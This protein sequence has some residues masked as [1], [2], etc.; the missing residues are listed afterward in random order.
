MTVQQQKLLKIAGTAL[1]IVIVAWGMGKLARIQIRLSDEAVTA[2]SDLRDPSPFRA[3][4][5]GHLDKAHLNALGYL[6]TRD[7]A[8]PDQVR[9]SEAEFERSVPEFERQ[10]PKLLPRSAGREIL[11]DYALFK[12]SVGR[13]LEVTRERTEHLNSWQLNADRIHKLIDLRLRP[14]VRPGQ[15]Q[16]EERSEA[17]LKVENQ[18]RAWE[19]SMGHLW[20]DPSQANQDISAEN[21]NKGEL[22]VE[23]ALDVAVLRA[24][25]Q[26]LKDVR[27]LW[28]ANADLQRKI[29]AFGTVQSQA[30]DQ[31]SAIRER[32][33]GTLNRLLPAMKP[34]DFEAKKSGFV[35]SMRGHLAAAGVIVLLGIVLLAAGGIGLH[36][37]LKEL[38]PESTKPAAGTQASAASE[39]SPPMRAPTLTIDGDG[40]IATWSES[41]EDLYGFK[42]NEVIGQ[43]IGI[44][45]ATESDINELYRQLKDKKTEFTSHQKTKEGAT[46]SVRLVFQALTGKDKGIA[47]ISHRA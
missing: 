45:F 20:D 31:E 9:D 4:L 44:L 1:A 38:A 39:N 7:G 21:A 27:D 19:Q 43:S 25:K 42:P 22:F 11:Q 33:R 32:M 12:E 3:A 13:L 18:L 5:L 46:I 16:S 47:L 34:E 29:V 8:L 40:K 37:L 15:E 28:R 23:K 36:R 30:Y 6:R 2:I 10:N 41:A 26:N 17:I 24:E 14:L 35:R